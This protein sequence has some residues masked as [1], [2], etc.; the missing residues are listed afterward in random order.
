MARTERLWQAASLV[1]GGMVVGAGLSAM[2]LGESNSAPIGKWSERKLGD[3]VDQRIE[4]RLQEAGLTEDQLDARIDQGILAFIAKQQAR[5]K[6]K[7][8]QPDDH[9]FGDRTAQ[10]TLIE[11]SDYACPYCKRFH[12]TAHRIVE[13][14]Q[15][16]VNWV[17]R[18]FPLSIHNPGAEIAAAGAEC[19]AELGGNAAF[20]AF[21]DRIFQ[22]ARPA[23]EAVSASELVSLAAELG[24]ARGQFK[25][26]LDS[27]RTRAAVRADVA[28]GEQAGITGTPAN[29]VYDNSSGATIAMVGA[30]PYE[31]FTRI[32]DQL[33][34]RSSVGGQPMNRSKQ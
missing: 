7:P 17:Y 31:Q 16:K 11:Y 19:A 32:I 8:I 10:I 34:A 21:S 4:Q 23:D 26:C 30:R 24:L 9:V 1:I 25:R 29:F 15:G 13:H 14:Y 6:V 5:Q 18:H 27:G 2:A 33:L 20:W 28:A 22:R 3:Y 12:A